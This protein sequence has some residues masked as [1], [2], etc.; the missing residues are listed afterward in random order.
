MTVP[1]P[2]QRLMAA[3][4]FLLAAALLLAGCAAARRMTDATAVD[5]DVAKAEVLFQQGRYADAIIACT[6]IHRRD[7]LTPGLEDLQGRIMMRLAQLREAGAAA[8][9]PASDRAAMVDADRQGLLPDTYRLRQH[10]IGERM[11]VSTPPNAM[12][13]ALA[14]PVSVHLENVSLSE[15]VSQI[16]AS[17]NVNIVADGNLGTNTLTI[18]VENAPLAEVL[19]Y[20]GR[21]LGVTFSVGENII[22][23]TQGNASTGTVPLVTR[24]YRLRKGLAGEE[25]EGG[26]DSLGVIEAITRFVPAIPGA[27]V[28]FNSKAHALLVK[29][30]RENCRLIED[31]IAALD[32]RPPQVLIEARFISVG[33]ADL[34]ELGVD[35]YLNSPITIGNGRAIVNG[36]VV[37]VPRTQVAA[38]SSMSY[39]PFASAAQGLNLTYEGVLTDPQFQAVLHALESSGRART[40]SVP[41]VT[42][43]NNKEAMLRVGEDFRYF[44]EFDIEEVR[45]GTTDEGRDIYESRLV[46]TGSPQLE[47]LG[48]ELVVTPSVGADLATIGLKL[49]P[50]ISEFV[51]WE[52]Y[53]SESS[54]SSDNDD[55]NTSTNAATGL[56][57]LPIFRRSVVNTEV[58]VH[59]GETVIMGGLVASTRNK[60]RTGTPVLSWLPLIGQLFRHDTFEERRQNLL[61]FVTA[62]L[63]S[64]AGEELIPIDASEPVTAAGKSE[65]GSGPS[66]D[67]AAVLAVAPP[68]APPVPAAPPATAVPPVADAPAPVEAP[69]P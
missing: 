23:V 38:G 51:R 67:E 36:D 49:A 68:I 63:L 25:I 19:E 35:W 5:P 50:E 47:E 53:A 54:G 1:P 15:I 10:V 52:Y 24:I 33:V 66:V 56:L 62:T 55:D 41:R 40:L 3:M 65:L 43:V 29:N 60:I 37:K 42:T 31:I 21:N 30:T 48:I 13:A 16:G 26:P 34:R 8:R 61:I 45:I 46:P 22:W 14:R 57:K 69:A 11:P 64:D 6:D 17:Q 12:Q 7:P 4:P 58:Q 20:V 2:R 44:E 9:S 39:A 59:S 18:H 27:D 28:L 32:V